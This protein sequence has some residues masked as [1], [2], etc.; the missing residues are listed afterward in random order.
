MAE[1][2]NLTVLEEDYEN[3]G[4]DI[5]YNLTNVNKELANQLHQ[6]EEQVHSLYT[7]VNWVQNHAQQELQQFREITRTGQYYDYLQNQLVRY[8]SP[9]FVDKALVKIESQRIH[10]TSNLY[11][12]NQGAE[13]KRWFADHFMPIFEIGCVLK[14]NNKSFYPIMLQA[15]EAEI[16]LNRA[17][18]RIN[19]EKRSLP[20]YTLHDCIL[21]TKGNEDYV[22]RIMK[23]EFAHCIGFQPHCKREYYG[24]DNPKL[25]KLPFF[26]AI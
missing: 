5:S 18:R 21:T 26:K 2:Y 19:T 22:E 15:M 10:F 24:P 8:V 7:L 3:K 13:A 17:A 20:I 23:E 6:Q 1:K 4:I 16:V 9:R 14:H 25:L 12:Y 11:Y